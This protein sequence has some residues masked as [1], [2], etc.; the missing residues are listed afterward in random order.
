VQKLL[1]RKKVASTPSN[2][3]K[4]VY[5]KQPG[6]NW[7]IINQKQKKTHSKSCNKNFPQSPKTDRKRRNN[8][9][10]KKTLPGL[11]ALQTLTSSCTAENNERQQ[12]GQYNTRAQ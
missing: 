9:T 8:K 7:T 3:K 11:S 2:P 12:G 4:A 6:L 10:E 1:Q 5:F